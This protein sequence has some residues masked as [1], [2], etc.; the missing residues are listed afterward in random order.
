MIWFILPYSA[1]NRNRR[2]YLSISRYGDENK[3]RLLNRVALFQD[4]LNWTRKKEKP[5]E[6]RRLDSC[7]I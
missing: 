1:R 4:V 5:S 3:K 7:W 2:L 6:V